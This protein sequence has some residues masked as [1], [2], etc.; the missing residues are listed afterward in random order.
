M[1]KVVSDYILENGTEAIRTECSRMTACIGQPTTFYEGYDAPA[2]QASTNYALGD[3]VRPTTRNNFVYEATADSGS[4]GVSE[5]TWPTTPG[6]TVVDGGITWTCR[7]S[8][9]LASQNMVTGDFTVSDGDTDGRKVRV[10]AKAGIPVF[11]TANADHVALL[12]HVN[13][14]LLAVTTCGSTA[15]ASGGT[16]DIAAFDYEVGDAT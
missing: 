7:T 8:R 9:A 12:D 5:P 16:V 15:L 14:R 4:S 10:G 6:N 1:A 11:R 3:S 13:R 2:W